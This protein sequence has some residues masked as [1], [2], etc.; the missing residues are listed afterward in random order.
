MI[1]LVRLEFRPRNRFHC[2]CEFDWVTFL[3]AIDSQ[4]NDPNIEINRRLLSWFAFF[5]YPGYNH[6]LQQFAKIELVNNI[7]LLFSWRNERCCD[8]FFPISSYTSHSLHCIFVWSFLFIIPLAEWP[9]KDILNQIPF[10]IGLCSCMWSMSAKLPKMKKKKTIMLEL[11]NEEKE[12]E[13]KSRTAERIGILNTISSN[14]CGNACLDLFNVKSTKS[15][16]D[17][18]K[19]HTK[20][21]LLSAKIR[22]K[23]MNR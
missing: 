12:T 19:A 10:N 3:N 2:L 17:K 7:Y 22:V 8:N 11:V 23:C 21:S 18:N 20:H 6:T 5:K 14:E 15:C 4:V 9:S 13:N 16:E 1:C